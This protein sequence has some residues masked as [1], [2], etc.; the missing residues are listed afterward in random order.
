MKKETVWKDINGYE[1]LYQVSSNGEV[2]RLYKEREPRV[3]VKCLNTIGYKVVTFSK[4]SERK[5]FYTHR[6]IAEYFIPNPENKPQINHKDG[7]KSNDNISNL[8]WCSGSENLLHAY[9]TGLK[10]VTDK[11][12]EAISKV[13]RIKVINTKTGEIYKS[14]RDTAKSANIKDYTLR[15]RLLN[16]LENNTNFMYYDLY[17]TTI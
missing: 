2:R 7:I 5:V 16:I 9:K 12:K 3:L 1:G 11:G 14:I 15:K 17:K 6:L 8:E 4:K 10:E 13:N